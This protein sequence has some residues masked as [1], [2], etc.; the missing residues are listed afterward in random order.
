M[1][2]HFYLSLALHIDAG[3]SP[4]S[5]HRYKYVFYHSHHHIMFMNYF[6]FFIGTLIGCRNRNS[7]L[8]IL[9]MSTMSYC[10][11]CTSFYF[12][13]GCFVSVIIYMIYLELQRKKHFSILRF[14]KRYQLK[15]LGMI[16]G[17]LCSS[18]M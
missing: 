4:F 3:L 12:S 14:I 2:F 13:V 7:P 1:I 8:N 5:F 9:L 17:C 18:F 15:F 11:M 16:L 10:I 6:P